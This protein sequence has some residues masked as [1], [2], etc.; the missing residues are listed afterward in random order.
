MGHQQTAHEAV[1]RLPQSL[2]VVLDLYSRVIVAWRVFHKED[3]ALAQQLFQEGVDR[4]VIPHWGSPMIARSSL[5]LMGKLGVSRPRVSNDTP[6]QRKPV[7]NQ[8][9]SARLPY[10]VREHY[11]CPAVVQLL[12]YWYNLQHREV[13]GFTPEQM[14][15]GRY[16]AI[17]EAR[18]QALEESFEAHPERFISGR[19][20]VAMLPE[21]VLISPVQPDAD[22]SAPYSVANFPTLSVASGTATKSK[23]IFKKSV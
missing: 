12:R 4:Y 1:R 5:G 13:A 16:R 19:P 21:S 20:E 22:D 8:Q 7:Q 3:V 18:Q 15:T 17:A 23:R 10:V 14:F 6:L 11:P 2:Y 9:V